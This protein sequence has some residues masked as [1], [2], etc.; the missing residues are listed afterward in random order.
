MLRR[1]YPH[2]LMNLWLSANH[3]MAELGKKH[4][5]EANT[6]GVGI[7]R[8]IPWPEVLHDVTSKWIEL[9]NCALDIQASHFGYRRSP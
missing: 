4:G 9:T 8:D 2:S 1:D 6:N 7:R 5:L 3:R